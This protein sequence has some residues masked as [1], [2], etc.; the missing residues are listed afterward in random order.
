MQRS[1]HERLTRAN[2]DSP[3]L[4]SFLSRYRRRRSHC[5]GS[6]P[7]AISIT[8]DY[9]KRFDYVYILGAYIER[10]CGRRQQKQQQQQ[11]LNAFDEKR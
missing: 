4:G 7:W 11:P 9:D 2:I 1:T 5:S 10:V 3:F 8:L 6:A